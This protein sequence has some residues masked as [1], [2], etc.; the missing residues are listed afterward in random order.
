[1]QAPTHH[2]GLKLDPFQKEAISALG[3]G[4]NVL[5]CA[6]TGTGKTLVAD[7]MVQTT[8]EA[9]G[10]VIYTA[11]IKALSNQKYRDYCALLGEDK[12]GLVTGD[13]VI[14]PDAPCRV[15]TTEILR[16]QLLCGEEH[17][18]LR[19]VIVDEIHFLD[20]RERGTT[21]EEVLIY[22]PHQI[23]VVGL[24]AT[25][26][27]LHEFAA[28]LEHV[29]ERPMRVIE[30]TTRAVPL[31]FQVIT[32]ESGMVDVPEAKRFHKDWSHKNSHA[33]RQ[34][35]Q[36]QRRG[37][38]GQRR[39]RR[40]SFKIGERTRHGL[41]FRN[42]HPDKTPYLYFCFS[43]RDTENLARQLVERN[44]NGL[45]N[46]EEQ[47]R[48]D[49]VIQTFLEQEGSRTALDG[50][51]E[52]MLRTGAAFHHAG[53]HVMLKNLVETLYEKRLI[54]V[55]YCTGTFALGINMPARTVVFDGLERFNG[56]EMIRLPA[57][58]FMQ[59]AGRAGRRGLD[60]HGLVVMRTDID[61]LGEILPQIEQYLQGRT[62]PVRSRF[63]LS[64]NSVVNLMER[65]DPERIRNIVERSYLN[66]VRARA[67]EQDAKL[68]E[69]VRKG[70]TRDGWVEG[71]PVP[72]PLRKRVKSLRRLKSK[73][74][75]GDDR[76]WRQFQ[77]KVDFLQRWSYL[78]EE[79]GLAAGAK[80]LRHVQIAEIFT[81]ELFLE[82]ALE[83]LQPSELFGV[84]CG[85]CN[86]LPRG[87]FAQHA[88]R[89]A[90]L[91]KHV[92]RIRFSDPVREAESLT[93]SEVTWDP[94]MIT[95]GKLWAEGAPLAEVLLEIV[96]PTD[97]SGDLIGAFRRA[98][99][100]AGQLGA[101]WADS[102]PER[103]REIRKLISSVSR[104]EVQVVG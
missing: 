57:R 54:K 81:T 42:L 30:E 45:L 25:L 96:A 75:R 46:P 77:E 41:I 36:S 4:E 47:G 43:R 6:P 98:K 37:R 3:A 12:V 92:A 29:R 1:M 97:L 66:F 28:W 93:N 64:F 7:W 38:H 22:L 100:L 23:Q 26:S 15:M 5:V 90:G 20:D 17:P 79:G 44:P 103:A 89:Y 11:P 31:H 84:L 2:R 63:S 95:P 87:A 50:E 9:G 72:P 68:I 58:E 67:V 55:L 40:D 39:G 76:T 71:D 49:E 35:K 94:Q 86:K 24:S 73:T 34:A 52:T 33:L 74:D 13:L 19:A 62:E 88:K 27:N 18:R 85:M 59:M 10:E 32:A 48:C 21:W 60:K 16:N 65:H 69:K 78:D 102:D 14:R 56:K 91:G 70:L 104:D 53:V 82:G 80:V 8:L 51:I 99:D 101:A 83:N 61:D